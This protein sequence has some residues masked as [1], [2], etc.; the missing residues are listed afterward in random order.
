M[1]CEDAAPL[2]VKARAYAVIGWCDVNRQR[3]SI[4][5]PNINIFGCVSTCNS[6]IGT[7]I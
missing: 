3:R 2:E 4:S 6:T 5:T 1:T 7:G